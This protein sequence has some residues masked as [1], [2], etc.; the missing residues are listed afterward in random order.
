MESKKF[1]KIE[2]RARRS[3]VVAEEG[4]I[5]KEEDR[6]FAFKGTNY[7]LK[8]PDNYITRTTNIYVPYMNLSFTFGWTGDRI[9]HEKLKFKEAVLAAR[10]YLSI[11]EIQEEIEE[12]KLRDLLM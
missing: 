7:I 6:I 11:N 9:P 12:L 10:G 1:A 8:S 4:I 5:T 2:V 3:L